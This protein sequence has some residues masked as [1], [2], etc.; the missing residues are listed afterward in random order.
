VEVETLHRAINP[1]V[2][3]VL[4]GRNQR[5]DDVEW[6][7]GTGHHDDASSSRFFF[8]ED[9]NQSAWSNRSVR[10]LILRQFSPTRPPTLANVSIDNFSDHF[11]NV[12]ITILTIVYY[13]SHNVLSI[14]VYTLGSIT[15]FVLTGR[16]RSRMFWNKLFFMFQKRL[17]SIIIIIIMKFFMLNYICEYSPHFLPH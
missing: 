7:R 10:V 1:W 12:H 15:G 2:S 16:P 11:T 3:A 14:F 8:T 4:W 17:I 6:T 13:P 5:F 9:N